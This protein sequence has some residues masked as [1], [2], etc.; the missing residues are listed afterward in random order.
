MKEINKFHTEYLDNTENTKIEEKIKK[1]GLAK[2][3][4]NES[5]T[6]SYDFN[7]NLEIPEVKIYDQKNSHQCNIY[8]FLRVIKSI[9]QQENPSMNVKKLDLS[10]NYLDFYDKFE[11]INALYDDLLFQDKVT[12]EM[13]NT[14]V[15]CYVGIYGTF[16]SC[17]ELVKKYGLVPTEVMPEASSNYNAYTTL[18]LLK[19]KIKSDATLLLNKTNEN[20]ELI[21]DQLMNEAYTFLAKV[22]GMPPI[23]FKYHDEVLT[24][25]EFR[26]KYVQC[27]LDDYV[28]VTSYDKETL[29]NSYAFTPKV[30]LEEKEEIRTLN[31]NDMKE[32]TLKQLQDGIAVWF[33]CEESTTLDYDLNILDDKTYRYN[34]MLNIK[35]L[36]KEE[37][38]ALDLI[39]YDHAMCITGA[40]VENGRIKQFKVDN[41]FGKHGSYKGQLIMTDSFFE[42]DVI[43]I[44]INKK[45]L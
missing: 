41:S 3:C 30:Y 1:E 38:Y 39:N 5:L 10:A 14:K 34:E 42:N 6:T 16:Y 32:A 11:K 19:A 25:I 2:A 15:N 29:F 7:F 18:E 40:L 8:A 36:S 17:K 43:T 12:L 35:D 22:M 33:S 31:I 9:M 26:E 13:I 27:N 21:K 23:D 44:I 45:Y 20:I 28:T 24:P 4:L 37:K